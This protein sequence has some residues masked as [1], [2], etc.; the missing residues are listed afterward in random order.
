MVTHRVRFLFAWLAVVASL[1]CSGA[2]VTVEE[3]NSEGWQR[4][5]YRLAS[6]DSLRDGYVTVS[7]FHLVGDAGATLTVVLNVSV[8]PTARLESG[9]WSAVAAA[10]ETDG[11]VIPVQVEFLGGQGGGAS[12]GGRFLLQAKGKARFRVDLP[13]TSPTRSYN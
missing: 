4:V 1:G 12:I 13:A 2:G 7:T 6:V 8:N 5:A 9:S 10:G 11:Q 3:R